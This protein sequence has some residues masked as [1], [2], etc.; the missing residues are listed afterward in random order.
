MTDL[1]PYLLPVA[2]D[3]VLWSTVRYIAATMTGLAEEV[4]L[5][6]LVRAYQDARCAEAARAI[7]AVGW[8]RAHPEYLP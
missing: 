8:V 6:L 7:D 1:P 3:P 2:A 4:A 5:A